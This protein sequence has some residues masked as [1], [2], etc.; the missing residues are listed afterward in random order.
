MF[1]FMLI[2]I[3]TLLRDENFSINHNFK[4]FLVAVTNSHL[5]SI[6]VNIFSFYIKE[7]ITAGRK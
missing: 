3:L 2:F 5:L 1:A 4:I 7:N 6:K